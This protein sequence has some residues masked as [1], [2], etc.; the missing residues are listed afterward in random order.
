LGPGGDDADER[1]DHGR[2]WARHRR[3]AAGQALQ[4]LRV[5]ARLAG[6]VS[7]GRVLGLALALVSVGGLVSTLRKG[8]RAETYELRRAWH[9]SSFLWVII[10]ISATADATRG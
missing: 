3:E 1:A 10:L 7:F 2:R 8:E 5:L 4:E 6:A 9:S